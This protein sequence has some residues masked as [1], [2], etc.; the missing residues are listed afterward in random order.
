LY[1][2]LAVAFL[3]A[4]LPSYI[5]ERIT[6]Y[7]FLNGSPLYGI[8]SPDRM[9]LFVVFTLLAAV[10]SGLLVGKLVPAAVA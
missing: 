10:A 6:E 5:V 7:Y 4:V 2:R 3:A 8:W 1:L 9:E